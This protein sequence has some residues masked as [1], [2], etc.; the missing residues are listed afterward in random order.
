MDSKLRLALLTRLGAGTDCCEYG[1]KDCPH[2]MSTPAHIS[3][4]KFVDYDATSESE[5]ETSS[6]ASNDSGREVDIGAM[7]DYGHPAA[8]IQMICDD[9]YEHGIKFDNEYIDVGVLLAAGHTALDIQKRFRTT[10]PR[11][12]KMGMLGGLFGGKKTGMKKKRKKKKGMLGGLF[13][14][15]KKK[16]KGKKRKKKGGF[17]GLGKKKKKKIKKKKKGWFGKKKKKKKKKDASDDGGDAGG[18]DGSGITPG[19]LRAAEREAMQMSNRADKAEDRA[20]RAEEQVDITRTEAQEARVEIDQL[21]MQLRESNEAAEIARGEADL[22]GTNLAQAQQEAAAALA[23]AQAIRDA[24]FGGDEQL[25]L[26]NTQLKT[27]E[28]E[29]VDLQNSSAATAEQ[30]VEAEAKADTAAANFEG[31]AIELAELQEQLDAQIIKCDEWLADVSNQTQNIAPTEA[32]AE[33]SCAAIEGASVALQAL[34]DRL[35]AEGAVIPEEV[36]QAMAIMNSELEDVG[37]FEEDDDDY[38]FESEAGEEGEAE[39]EAVEVE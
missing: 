30:L 32:I 18:G 21:T 29:L 15:K 17:F 33:K 19:E 38:D 1:K 5:W 20:I 23:D 13:G 2:E 12:K 31:K 24:Q 39:A 7:L 9:E 14:G 28:D 37:E 10:G 8:T 3:G 6:E 34:I 25:Q 4:L 35:T 26:L 27:A 16:K 36:T 11:K 22:C